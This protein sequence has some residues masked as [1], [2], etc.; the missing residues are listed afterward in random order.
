[1]DTMMVHCTGCRAVLRVPADTSGRWARCPAC[2]TK[3]RIPEPDELL[4]ETVSSWLEQETETLHRMEEDGRLS[5]VGAG[6]SSHET[7]YAAAVDP[8]SPAP[9]KPDVP[10]V[11]A[12]SSV[13]IEPGT[14]SHPGSTVR[15]QSKHVYWRRKPT[16]KP[17][18]GAADAPPPP[19]PSHKPEKPLPVERVPVVPTARSGGKPGPASPPATVEVPALS[20]A[21]H[22]ALTYPT[23]LERD[24]VAPHLVVTKTSHAGITLAFDAV[25]LN[26]EAFRAAIPVRCVFCG[27]TKREELIA[28]PLLFLDRALVD[29]ATME[30]VAATHEHRQI[31]DRTA[32]Q[33][34]QHMGELSH[35]PP[36]FNSAMPVFVSTRYAHL[37][38]HCMT[39][40]RS[41]G[42]I[43]CEVLIPDPHTALNWLVNVNGM[44][45]PEYELLERECSLL[46]GE[47]WR[48]LTDT[49]RDRIGYWCKLQPGEQFRQFITDSDFGKRDEGLGGLVLTD[50]RLVYCKYHHRGQVLLDD[51][52]TLR[53]KVE[54]GFATLSLITGNDRVRMVKIAEHEL[55]ALLDTVAQ[56][57]GLRYELVQDDP[58]PDDVPTAV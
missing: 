29:K 21:G 25:W 8:R 26:H 6:A 34:A 50:Q 22:L 38:I 53:I 35:M 16:A 58:R 33:I 13:P 32:R 3:F 46:H 28:R 42:G 52:A 48:S 12:G 57:R 2:K 4:D 45:G 7:V 47:A 55:T 10:D 49:C 44:C 31:G 15:R 18:G 39:R 54:G 24:P 40:N 36:P 30:Q 51:E 56:A 14:E 23:S 37:P 27:R 41:D 5:E 17:S 19:P 43:T 11:V 1:M 9:P 20:K